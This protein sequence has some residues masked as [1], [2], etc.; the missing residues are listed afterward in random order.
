MRSTRVKLAIAVAVLGVVV[1]TTA[2]VAGG[3]GKNSARLSGFQEVPVVL[4]TGEGSFKAMISRTEDRIDY[5]LRYEDLEGIPV[6]Q[7][8]IHVGQRL[9]N[10]GIAVWLCGNASTTPPVVTPPPGTQPCPVGPD[11][12]VTGTITPA[13][14]VGVPSQGVDPGEFD[15]L[16]RAIRLGLTYANVHTTKSPAGEIRGQ[17]GDKNRHKGRHNGDHDSHDD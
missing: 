8:H 15:E 14:I 12:E 2:A 13:N 17:I 3:G 9:A 16:V 5:T 7:A 10:G 4:T 6:T 1:T 11:G